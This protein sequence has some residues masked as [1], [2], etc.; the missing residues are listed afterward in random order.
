MIENILEDLIKIYNF[1]SEISF[2]YDVHEM[3]QK[4]TNSVT[5][6]VLLCAAIFSTY[7]I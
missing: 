1:C 6:H 2:Y 5:I 4:I 7:K 3:K